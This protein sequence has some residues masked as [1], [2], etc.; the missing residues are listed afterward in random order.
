M[1]DWTT[2]DGGALSGWHRAPPGARTMIVFAGVAFVSLLIPNPVVE[3]VLSALGVPS[4]VSAAAPPIGLG[5]RVALALVAG[6]LAAFGYALSKWSATDRAPAER[7]RDDSL[8]VEPLAAGREL[9]VRFDDS[10]YLAPPPP[11]PDA[12]LD[13]DSTL[14]EPRWQAGMAVEREDEWDRTVQERVRGHEDGDSVFAEHPVDLDAATA[15]PGNGAEQWDGPAEPVVAD[16]E[17]DEFD[18]RLAELG[19]AR[20]AEPARFTPPAEPAPLVAKVN[21]API[22]RAV[23]EAVVAIPVKEAAVAPTVEEPVAV[24]PDLPTDDRS[25]PTVVSVEDVRPV[26]RS[27]E[28]PVSAE[29]EAVSADKPSADD[30]LNK[31]MTLTAERRAPTRALEPDAADRLADALRALRVVG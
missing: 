3:G 8:R 15:Q 30:L 2:T 11:T 12:R 10:P 25:I 29:P 19:L 22:A 24:A 26:T 4:L 23:E 20:A 28:P 18:R 9:G 6:W 1:S 14:G 13:P 27:P 31:L 16:D 7:E 17:Q 21:P 5:G